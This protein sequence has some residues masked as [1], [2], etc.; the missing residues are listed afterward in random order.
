MT[1]HNVVILG[2]GPAGLTA[3]YELTRNQVP[4]TVLERD[5]VVGGIARTEFYKGYGYDIGGHRFYTKMPEVNALWH[6]V[7]GDE[8]IR[9]PRLSRIH[10][11]GKFFYYP[12]RLLNVL[13]AL[14]IVQSIW[15]F[16]SFVR[17]R[18]F[19]LVPEE[20]FEDYVSNRF[21]RKLYHLFFK[22]YTEKV[23]GIPCTEIRAEWAAQRIRGLSFTS[24]LKS[25]IFQNGNGIKSLIEEFEYPRRGPGMMWEAFRSAVESDG[26]EVWLNAPVVRVNRQGM[27]ITSVAV[28]QNGSEREVAG[29]HFVSTLALRDLINALNPPPPPD[30]LKAANSLGYRDFLTVILIVNVPELFPDNWIYIHTPRVHVG[31]IQNFK[32]WSKGM[33]PDLTK[34]SLGMEYFVNEGDEHWTMP[35]DQLIELAKRELELIGLAR[36][37]QVIDGTVKRM[38]KAY[39][40]YDST[41]HEHLGIVRGYLDAIENLQT[42]GRNGMHKYNNQDHSMMTALLAARNI[43]GQAHDVWAVNTDMEYQEELVIHTPHPRTRDR[44]RKFVHSLTGGPGKRWQGTRF[45]E[46]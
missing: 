14:G 3:A 7:L 2:A 10:Y 20:S 24:A 21:G 6:Q 25:A 4:V 22:T 13:S 32:N 36:A 34:T 17:A 37:D 27:C 16:L 33:L 18:L 46:D 43:L 30:V 1:E 41:Y 35:D 42:V 26:G 9:V 29:T 39:P 23:W 38:R 45:E 11:E 31:R 40:V 44:L 19:P 5:N 28:K 12:L 15:I 8:F